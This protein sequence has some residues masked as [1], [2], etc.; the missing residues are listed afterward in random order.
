LLTQVE[1]QGAK[2]DRLDTAMQRAM[3]KQTVVTA[4]Q[5]KLTQ[6]S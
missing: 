1:S 3:E 4:R 6:S 2:I 5:K